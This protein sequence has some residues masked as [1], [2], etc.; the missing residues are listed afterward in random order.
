MTTMVMIMPVTLIRL[1]TL[2]FTTVMI[3]TDHGGDDSDDNDG[4]V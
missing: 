4:N 1:L 2:T 3:M